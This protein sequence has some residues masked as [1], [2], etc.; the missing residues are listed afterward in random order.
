MAIIDSS[1]RSTGD[2]GQCMFS[3]LPLESSR[4]NDSDVAAVRSQGVVSPITK[5]DDQRGDSGDNHDA[6]SRHSHRPRSIPW[7]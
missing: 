3:A 4:S 7:H 5:T 1:R 6:F 2:M